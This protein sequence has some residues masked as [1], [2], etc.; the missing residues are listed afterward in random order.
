MLPDRICLVTGASQGMGRAAAI[1]MARQGA[2]AVAVVDIQREAGK[3][4]P[5]WSGTR[6]QGHLRPLR[7]APAGRDRGGGGVRRGA[8]RR[9]GRPAQQR[10]SARAGLHQR[11]RFRHASRRPGDLVMDINLKAVWLMSRFA[12]PH[13]RRSD[14]TP[15]I[16]DAASVGRFVAYSHAVYWGDQ[17]R[18]II[19]LT[20]TMAR[21]RW[22]RP[23]SQLLCP[24]TIDTEMAT[25]PPPPEPRTARREH[26]RRQPLSAG[27]GTP[28]GVAEARLLPRLGGCRFAVS[29]DSAYLMET[30]EP[31]GLG[32]RL[33]RSR[34]DRA[35]A[36]LDV[37]PRLSQGRGQ[38]RSA[39]VH[40]RLLHDLDR[41]DKVET[42]STCL[43]RTPCS[44]IRPGSIRAVQPS[45][46]TTRRSS[47]TA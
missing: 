12:A 10:G 41:I 20:K 40:R 17:G 34:L 37:E 2:A 18:R 5:P 31:P 4:R 13:L 29:R 35:S 19:Q 38:G 3:K 25:T 36:E 8:V 16:V 45:S 30:A 7:P 43:P 24:G 22:P 15:A 27:K 26:D 23:S 46:P 44:G 6:R 21:L 39:C 32:G 33:R 9:P 42:W 11:R 28:E 1:E 14:R 47:P